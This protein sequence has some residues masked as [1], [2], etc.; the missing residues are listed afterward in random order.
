M[1]RH[2]CQT[3]KPAI[4]SASH[5]N[6]DCDVWYIPSGIS[7]GHYCGLPVLRSSFLTACDRS[8]ASVPQKELCS[9]W[10]SLV[11]SPSINTQSQN[12][13]GIW[14][15]NETHPDAPCS[16]GSKN[17][18]AFLTLPPDQTK[19]PSTRKKAVTLVLTVLF[20][21]LCNFCTHRHLVHV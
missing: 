4:N 19:T 17:N 2:I 9:L 16:S 14:S 11:Q 10:I 3:H 20:T 15:T 18:Q 13:R 12:A 7:N 8:I 6:W 21:V 1:L 5:V